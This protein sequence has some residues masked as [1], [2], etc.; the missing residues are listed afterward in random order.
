MQN[1][2]NFKINAFLNA[3]FGDDI[4]DRK[5]TSDFFSNLWQF[6]DLLEIEKNNKLLLPP[7]LNMS[8][9]LYIFAHRKYYLLSN[10]V[11]N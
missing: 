6:I 11:K 10:Y 2:K 9:Y 5:I 3:S 7:Q 4:N 8:S 1:V